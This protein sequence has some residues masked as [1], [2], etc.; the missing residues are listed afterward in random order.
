MALL[1]R[2]DDGGGNLF[3]PKT[4]SVS[5]LPTRVVIRSKSRQTSALGNSIP[6]IFR[7]KEHTR[8]LAVG[9]PETSVSKLN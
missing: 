1:C 7:S 6:E 5:D 9:R 2:P 8:R 3:F 4:F